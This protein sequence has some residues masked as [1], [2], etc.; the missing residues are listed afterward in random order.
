MDWKLAKLDA[1]AYTPYRSM[2]LS[3]SATTRILQCLEHLPK[4]SLGQNFLIDSNIVLKALSLAQLQ[5]GDV[6]VEI[7][8]GIGT[9]SEALLKKGFSLYAV[10]KDP[11]L[12]AYL[13]K[14]LQAQYP[15]F[16]LSQG[17]AMDSP[18]AALPASVSR[19]KIVANLPYA[20]S[21]PWLEKILRGRLPEAMVLMLQKETADRFRA[22]F[23]TK[24]YSPISILLEGAY[25]CADQHAVSR[26][27]FHPV[28]KVDSILLSL[29]RKAEPFVFSDR[30]Y[31]LMRYLFTQRR[32]QIQNLCRQQALE[33]P[34]LHLWLKRLEDL[35]L[36]GLSRPEA[37]PFVAWQALEDFVEG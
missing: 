23:G 26:Q 8:P 4:K 12:Y 34:R 32:K 3:P 18:L 21:T 9:L 33:Y 15:S 31:K 27:C 22:S 30:A 28:P 2:T 29:K 20:I 13:L 16:H 24:A 36:S 1:A 37:I 5:T 6:L 25:T 11:K 14:H 7:G 19:F 17:D 10:E 35:G